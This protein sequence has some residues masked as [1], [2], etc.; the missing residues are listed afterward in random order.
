MSEL[1]ATSSTVHCTMSCMY[2]VSE[3]VRCNPNGTNPIPKSKKKF[4]DILSKKSYRKNTSAARV[5]KVTVQLCKWIIED[6]NSKKFLSY[7]WITP[8]HNTLEVVVVPY[9]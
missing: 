1:L 4:S 7:E 2:G 9:S 5:V 6:T 3:V 8:D